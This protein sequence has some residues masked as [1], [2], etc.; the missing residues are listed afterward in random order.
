M[1]LGNVLLALIYGGIAVNSHFGVHWIWLSYVLLA[2]SSVVTPLTSTG[3][4]QLVAELLPEE[5]RSTANFFDDVYLHLTWLVGPAI[6][7]LSVAWLG[8]GLVLVLDAVSFILCAIFL[9]SIP[10]SLHT[11]GT[12]F[13]QLSRNLLDGVKVLKQSPLLLQLGG[14]TFFFNFFF[15]IYAV[16]LPIVARNNFGG[17]KAYG[18]LWSAFAVGSFIG[19]VIFSRKPWKL[20]MGPSMTTVIILWG[21]LTGL[22]SFAHQYWMVFG[23]MVLNGL[24]YTPYEPL[25]R[26][27]IQQ[28]VPLRMQAK[29][30][31]T[32]RP[33]T[34]LGQPTG[35]WLSGL[36]AT[37][38]GL[39]GLVLTSGVATILVG[40]AT[41]MTPR[42]RN[43]RNDSSEASISN[44]L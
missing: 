8:Y 37:P 7:G 6:A 2:L 38:L 36:L 23:I 41:F 21:I 34:G 30:S 13:S 29:V 20:A 4:S 17:A 42:I 28:V 12:R 18:L 22:L 40:C 24:V 32:I 25:Y 1:V 39:T 3:R 14:L 9:F 31:S 35:S 33:I 10:S 5:E 43:Y 16:V 19:G 11:P 44:S 15:G 26:T 27:I